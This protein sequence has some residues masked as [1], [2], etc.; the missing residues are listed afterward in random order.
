MA[1]R[2][3]YKYWAFAAIAIGMFASVVDHGSI[4]IAMPTIAGHFHTN[5]PTIQWIAI[6]YTLTIS[7][8]LLPMGR[9][10]D[11]M[12]R[13]RVYII[14]SLVFVAAAALAGASSSLTML[15]L[16]R[17]LQGCGAAMTQGT[18]MAIVMSAFPAQERGKSIG[19]I[20]TTVGT[21]AIA[22]P[23]VGGL[24]V[25]ALGWRSVLFVNIPLVLMGI[26]AS[27]AILEGARGAKATRGSPQGKFDWLGAALS[28]GALVTFL[29]AI[30]NGHKSGWTS[31]P[32]LTA[33]LGSM[34]LLG[35]F[36]WWELRT[37]APMLDLR[38][39][40]RRVFSYGVSAHFITFLGGSAVLFLMPFYLQ[41][42]LGYSPGEAG[43]IVVPNAI[44]ITLLGPLSGLLSDRY[45]W[46]WFTVG[47]LALSVT[48]LLILSRVS[49]NSSLALVMPA[50]ML[51]S[52]GMGLFYSP[53]SSSILST[54]ERE[55]YGVASAFLNLIRNTA[56][57]TSLAVATAIVTATMASLGHEPSLEAVSGSGGAGVSHAFTS[58][59][60]NAYLAMM[61]LVVV[62]MLVSALKGEKPALS[63]VE[64]PVAS[65][66]PSVE[67][68]KKPEQKAQT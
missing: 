46:R 24:L 33:L 5:L 30:T 3:N 8:L 51:H 23:A 2:A 22:G 67:G 44:C 60:R 26:V 1:Q 11:L 25:D 34:A 68:H 58:G 17:V 55:R 18:G 50:L 16:A 13:K 53:N 38:L 6:G 28:T 43:L 41:R 65:P 66:S 12:G 48:G 39:F 9:L 47:G 56:N 15:I 54:V 61:G 32:I 14:G 45:G 49:E 63:G 36:I 40:Q 37:P 64:G 52:S 35:S 27:L 21:G 57:V 7:A 20:M 10:S 42:V 29:L 62:G 59:M 19:L 4:N 31:P